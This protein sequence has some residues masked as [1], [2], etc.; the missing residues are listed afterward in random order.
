MLSPENEKVSLNY[1]LCDSKVLTS[2]STIL[3]YRI[4]EIWIEKGKIT[5]IRQGCTS[6]E[7]SLNTNPLHYIHFLLCKS[8]YTKLVEKDQGVSHCPIVL[9]IIPFKIALCKD[10]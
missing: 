9:I 10:I 8:F 4:G 6:A 7:E 2:T 1:L 5:D 3:T